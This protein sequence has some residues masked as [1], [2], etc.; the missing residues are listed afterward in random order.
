M[1][2][3]DVPEWMALKKSILY[4]GL[5][6]P[7]QV[8][9]DVLN[10]FNACADALTKV[11]PIQFGGNADYSALMGIIDIHLMWCLENNGQYTKE[12]WDTKKREN[13]AELLKQSQNHE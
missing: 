9:E 7:E 5:E 3:T 4:L 10:K 6:L 12:E 8:H 11:Q 1:R 2:L 13:L